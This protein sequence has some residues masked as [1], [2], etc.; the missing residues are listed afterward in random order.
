[1]NATTPFE[2]Q[3]CLVTDEILDNIVHYTDVSS[4]LNLT[5]ET[6]SDVKLTTDKT[7]IKAFIGILC[8]AGALQSNKQSL[9]KL[10]GTE[11]NGNEKFRSVMNQGCFKFLIRCI[12]E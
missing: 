9:E 8:L 7:D 10:C 2:V 11:R 5:S 4:L 3:K 12:L 6:K 1:M